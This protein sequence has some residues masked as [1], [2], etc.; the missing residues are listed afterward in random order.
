MNVIWDCTWCCKCTIFC[1]ITYRCRANLHQS[2]IN[3]NIFVSTKVRKVLQIMEFSKF[4]YVHCQFPA[5]NNDSVSLINVLVCTGFHASILIQFY[6]ST[7]LRKVSNHSSRV[8]WN[9]FCSYRERVDLQGKFSN[10][11]LIRIGN[12]F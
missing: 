1:Y 4:R 10:A 6:H 11:P 9:S 7:E 5:S 8:L 12:T 2:S 3:F